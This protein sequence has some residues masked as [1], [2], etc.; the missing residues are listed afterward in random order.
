MHRVSFLKKLKRYIASLYKSLF[1]DGFVTP[2]ML[3]VVAVIF[4]IELSANAINGNGVIAILH[5]III[6]SLEVA[7]VTM[8]LIALTQKI[9]TMIRSRR[10]T[11]SRYVRRQ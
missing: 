8:L 5:L 10:Q 7:I 9:L 4:G 11:A 2:L 1:D 6:G 3:L